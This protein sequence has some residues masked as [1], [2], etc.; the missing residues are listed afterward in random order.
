[1]TAKSLGLI[2]TTRIFDKKTKTTV[3][4]EINDYP[5][6]RVISPV[7]DDFSYSLT[8]RYFIHS[9]SVSFT[10]LSFYKNYQRV[11]ILSNIIL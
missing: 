4:T 5:P 11:Y 3:V 7:F 10:R 6:H 9:N 2:P 8:K 1:M